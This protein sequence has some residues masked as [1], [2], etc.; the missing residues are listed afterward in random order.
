VKSDIEVKEGSQVEGSAGEL[1]KLGT[2]RQL[3][4]RQGA[5]DVKE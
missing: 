4:G 5:G 1:E 3:W 2:S